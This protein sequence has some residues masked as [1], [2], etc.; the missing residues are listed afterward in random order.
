MNRFKKYL[1]AICLTLSLFACSSNEA[2]YEIV[3]EFEFHFYPE[4]YEEEY[5]ETSKTLTLDADIDYQLQ[6]DATCEFGTMDIKVRYGNTDEKTY[7]IGVDTPYN[8]LIILPANVAYEITIIA[9]V[10]PDTKG[11]VIGKLL[12]TTK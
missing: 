8:E 6:H 12:A 3:R 9:S 4:E 11:T 10:M 5:K 7:S 1:M 2:D